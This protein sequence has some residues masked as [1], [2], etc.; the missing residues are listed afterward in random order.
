[1]HLKSFKI[2]VFTISRFE[3]LHHRHL[4]FQNK[5][6]SN[7]DLNWHQTSVTST[8]FLSLQKEGLK[9]VGCLRDH[10][11][12]TSWVGRVRKWQLLM[13]YSTVNNQRVGWVGLKKSKTWWRNTCMVPKA[14]I[15]NISVRCILYIRFGFTYLSVEYYVVSFQIIDLC[16]N[17]FQG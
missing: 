8:L 15:R 3:E 2:P 16:S 4:L 9:E 12:I 1:M 11:S 7:S 13:I 17:G 6:L 5:S 10:S 14:N